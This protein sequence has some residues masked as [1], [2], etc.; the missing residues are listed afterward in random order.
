MQRESSRIERTDRAFLRLAV[1]R[2]YLDPG[3]AKALSSEA[4]QT[5]VSAE[6]LAVARGH[7]STRRL[8]RLQAHLRFQSLRRSDK[9]YARLVLELGWVR[10]S[11][12]HEA[13][14]EQR[15]RFSATR[16]RVRL[17]TLLVERGA[18]TV[19]Q[20]RTLCAQRCEEHDSQQGRAPTVGSST[21]T[22]TFSAHGPSVP[23]LE[24]AVHRVEW[25]RKLSEQMGQ[26]E[27]PPGA[28]DWTR[29]SAAAVEEI[30]LRRAEA[31][32]NA[33]G[34]S[35]WQHAATQAESQ[36]EPL[37]GLEATARDPNAHPPSIAGRWKRWFSRAG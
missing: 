28:G 30:C 10:K 6:R 15:R 22:H 13:L 5:G 23:Q 32:R 27:H 9:Q 16:E 17:G 8:R 12:L 11:L 24:A 29:D 18:L 14:T 33:A 19:D 26:S 1:E 21:L 20:D 35:D 25:L 31:R 4:T 2:G 7:L 37:A 3:V 34:D 36:A